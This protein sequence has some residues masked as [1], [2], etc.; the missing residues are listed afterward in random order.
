[1][2]SAR[3]K[4]Q[5]IVAVAVLILINGVSNNTAEAAGLKPGYLRCE[6]KVDPIGIDETRPRLSWIVTSEARGAKQTA[7]QVIVASNRTN[8]DANKA[9]FWD[10]GKVASDETAHVVYSGKSLESEKQVFWKVRVWDNGG[11]VSAW[12]DTAMWS[13]GLLKDSDWRAK[14]IGYDQ[15]VSKKQK[16]DAE[17]SAVNKKLHKKAHLPSPYLRKDF[18]LSKSVKKA[19]VY[20]TALGFY[21]LYINGK[22]IGKDYFTPGWTDYNKR[23]YY[24]TYDV[25]D[26]VKPGAGNAVG[27][28]LAEG[29]YA[30]NVGGRGQNVYGSQLRLRAQIV[31]NYADGS[32]QI[33]GTD[34]TWKASDGPIREADMQDGETYDARLEMRGWNE[35]GFNDSAWK[36]V[37]VT[38]IVKA[39]IQAYPG[40]PVRKTREVKP[41]GITEPKPGVFIYDLGQNFAGCARLKVTGKEGTKIVLRFGE[42]LDSDGSL[43]TTNL[44][45]A[46]VI[47]TYI[48]KGGAEETWEPDFTYHGFRYVE[49][50]GY[51]G[52]PGMD[53]ITGIVM[54]SDLPETSTFATSMPLVNRLYSNIVW[55]QRSN[56]F[57]VP[58]DCPQRDER[59]GWM[60]DAQVFVR[61]ASYNMDIAPFFTKWMVDVEDGQRAD[62]AFTDVAPA[63]LTGVSSA[64]ADAGVI[65]PWTI[66]NVYGDRRIVEKHYKSMQKWIDFQRQRSGN[67]LSFIGGYGDWLNVNQPTDGGLISTAYYGR[68]VDLLA[69]MAEAVDR[70][71]DAENYR[72][73]YHRIGKAFTS[74]FMA[75]D[76]KI[77]GDT[78]TGYLM[79]L[80][81]GLIPDKLRKPAASHLVGRIKDREWSLATGFL[82]C[83]LLLPT[84]TEIGRTDVA[85]RLLTNRKYPSWGYSIDQGAT[86]TWERWN[87]YTKENGFGDPGMNS[88]N[89]YAYGA[90]GEWMFSTL[91]GIDLEEPGYRRILIHPRPGGGLTWAEA[92]Y[93]SIRGLIAVSWKFK[94]NDLQLDVTIPA[95]TAATVYIPAGSEADV[96]EGGGPAAR[97]Q[98]VKFLR[99][100]SGAAVYEIGSGKYSFVSKGGRTVAESENV[101]RQ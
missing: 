50:T 43:Y 98:G 18:S 29:W 27:A 47:D 5:L 26:V 83:S 55:G 23:I 9:D 31:I 54:H 57:E 1:M 42:M 70:K 91:A 85:Y 86:T 11:N 77:S 56:Y 32:K 3:S 58:T 99:M 69:Q 100:E 97:S 65:C 93:N 74:Y 81:F 44:R 49:V 6:Y 24:Q 7:Y 25:T 61:T 66:Y 59:L 68:S 8:I 10:S 88:F 76:G 46:R 40:I 45:G 28:I 64:W 2:R 96:A 75:T 12:S 35:G 94:D 17:L 73:L 16:L 53:A 90:V 51:P 63:V 15:K 39:M 41:I 21:E 79:A 67:N 34:E 89:H 38:E 19:T 4:T 72:K 20:A 78:Q 60:G 30:G 13:M 92:S 48:L 82:G 22:R 71:E 52:K 62:G 33:I 87:S 14:W 84:L 101:L 95:N 37:D 80:H 36:N